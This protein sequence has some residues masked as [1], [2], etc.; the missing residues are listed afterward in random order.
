MYCFSSFVF[1]VLNLNRVSTGIP[2]YG[3]RTEMIRKF[4]FPFPLWKRFRKSGIT[5]RFP[6]RFFFSK[7]EISRTL[8]LNYETL[9]KSVPEN[10][11]LRNNCSGIFRKKVPENVEDILNLCK[12]LNK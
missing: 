9:R 6:E 3:L 11:V 2:G 7:P 8:I 5:E 10:S 4:F 1:A 12:R